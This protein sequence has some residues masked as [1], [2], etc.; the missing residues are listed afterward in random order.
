MSSRQVF[1]IVLAVAVALA[2]LAGLGGIG[3]GEV[4]GPGTMG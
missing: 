1:Y 3:S 4:A 2:L